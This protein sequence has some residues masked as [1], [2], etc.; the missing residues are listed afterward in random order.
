MI[1]GQTHAPAPDGLHLPMHTPSPKIFRTG[2]EQ[3]IL[4]LDANLIRDDG[5]PRAVAGK[6]WPALERL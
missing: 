3:G 2:S 6:H 1:P 4:G 5:V